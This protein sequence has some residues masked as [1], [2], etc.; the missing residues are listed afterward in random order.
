MGGYVWKWR[1][2][3]IELKDKFIEPEWLKEAALEFS[4]EYCKMVDDLFI[5]NLKDVHRQIDIANLLQSCIDITRVKL[6]L[7]TLK[8]FW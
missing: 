1:G 7:I 4:R 8:R 2:E 5:E 6:I 3:G